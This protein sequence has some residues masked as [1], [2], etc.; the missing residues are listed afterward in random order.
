M[1]TSGATECPLDLVCLPG[2]LFLGLKGLLTR[3]RVGSLGY[4]QHLLYA[5][6]HSVQ[7]VN[8]REVK[9]PPAPGRLQYM[10]SSIAS[11]TQAGL[12]EQRALMIPE[13]QHQG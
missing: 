11:T 4:L 12:A 3:T 9:P 13:P 6:H 5:K 1:E 2:W 8:N 10:H 7:A